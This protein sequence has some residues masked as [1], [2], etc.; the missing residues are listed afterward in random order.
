[1]AFEGPARRGRKAVVTETDMP[2]VTTVAATL[3][4]TLAMSAARGAAGQTLPTLKV[5]SDS[6]GIHV[7][8]ALLSE[9]L[10]KVTSG[11]MLETIDRE[12]DWYW[13]ILPADEHG[14]RYPGW[15]RA[16][17][18]EIVAAGD[19]RAV[20]H[21]FTEAVEQA[22]ARLDAQAAEDAARL[23]RARQKV[24]EA[25]EAYDTL[26]KNGP[27]GSPKP[28]AQTQKTAVRVPS[29]EKPRANVPREYEWF[30]GYSFYRDQSDGESFGGGWALSGARQVTPRIDLVGTISASHRGEDILGVNV[31][32]SSIHTFAGGPK[33]AWPARDRFT[34]FAQVLVGIATVS[35]SAFGI[36]TSSTGFALQP[37]FGVDVPVS[38]PVSLRLGFDVETI[39]AGGGWFTGFRINAGMTVVTGTN[40]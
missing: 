33:Y 30:G 2:R 19:P 15:V 6:A 21:H 11:T 4:F 16:S 1:M 25:R 31:A 12:D 18:V 24:E 10:K 7:R 27:A 32:S 34:P 9:T 40:K 29:A 14:T 17:E 28:A 5:V 20:L 36:D 39:H 8:P 37:G 26:V 23:E 35:S 22:K 3:V 13:V 38:K